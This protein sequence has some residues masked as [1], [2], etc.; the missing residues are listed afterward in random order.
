MAACA[1]PSVI[2]KRG[3]TFIGPKKIVRA[4]WTETFGQLGFSPATRLQIGM[5]CQEWMHRGIIATEAAEAVASL[6]LMPSYTLGVAA[7]PE[8]KC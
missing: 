4:D 8:H 1:W 6:L 3:S 5:A 2:M 7:I